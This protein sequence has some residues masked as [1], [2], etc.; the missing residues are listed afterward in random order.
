MNSRQFVTPDQP[1]DMVRRYGK[2][3]AL[4]IHLLPTTSC[5]APSLAHLHRTPAGLGFKGRESVG[6]SPREWAV[7]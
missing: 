3:I 4:Y 1:E 6:C 7:G 2:S 5:H